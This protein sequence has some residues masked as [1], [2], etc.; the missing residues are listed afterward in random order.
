MKKPPFLLAM[1]VT[2]LA[3]L[4]A[5]GPEDELSQG[6][7][8]ETSSTPVD[9]EGDSIGTSQSE[10]HVSGTTFALATHGMEG[11]NPSV[12]RCPPSYVAV[13][14]SGRA[15]G[16]IN[17]LAL[18]CAYMDPN[19]N[20]SAQYITTGAVGSG[21]G[22]SFFLMCL[23]NQAVVGFRGSAG[24]YVDR[25]GL[26]CSTIASWQVSTAVQYVSPEAGGAGGNS[27]SELAP[28]AFV[29]T[30]LKVRAS[31]VIDQFQ[32]IASYISP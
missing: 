24:S 17:H 12:L 14:L 25:V 29:V 8:D 26:Y 15:A 31:G 27:F 11:G 30:S 22:Q 28:Q 19:G 21:G 13:G 6:M 10:L 16:T 5:C 18:I 4:S 7:A 1:S 20:L 2:S 9:P 32:G 3:L 23:A